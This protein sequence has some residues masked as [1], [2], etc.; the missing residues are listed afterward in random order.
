MPFLSAA[1]NRHMAVADSEPPALRDRVNRNVFGRGLF[2]SCANPSCG[3][4]WLHPL[5]GHSAPVFE[6]GW[7][8]SPECTR[9]RIQVAIAREVEGR[10]AGRVAY[11]HR[12]PLGL[13]LL[14]QGWINERQLR[15]AL[16]AQ[17]QAGG[18][19]IGA[20][21]VKQKAVS[22]ETVARALAVQWS[23]PV[24]SADGHDTGTL[25][26]VMPRL[27]L[28]AFGALPVRL[29]GSGVLYLGFESKLDPVLALAIGRM[30]DLRVECGVVADSH[31][32][33][34]H[35]RMLEA[36]FP[37]VS[38]IEAVSPAAAALTLA[39]EVERTRPVA[40]RLVRAH[41]YLWLRQW[42]RPQDRTPHEQGTVHDLVCS[43]GPV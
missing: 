37:P 34:A 17:K 19:R 2:A 4:G 6:G 43:L 42:M 26:A 41:D 15:M 5:R 9:A 30:T 12:I 40:S 24:I 11:R 8:C 22:E 39:R 13:V 38:L 29:A 23:C 35:A 25:T 31:F 7:T 18:G 20:W 1:K 14:Q 32:R 16:D 33:S 10:A 28:D 27:F 36:P 3:S 21:L